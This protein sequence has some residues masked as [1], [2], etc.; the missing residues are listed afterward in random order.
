[1][2]TE[3]ADSWFPGLLR[4]GQSRTESSGVTA[5]S[6]QSALA[7]GKRSQILSRDGGCRSNPH[8]MHCPGHPTV[9]GQLIPGTG[10]ELV[11]G[12]GV[13]FHLFNS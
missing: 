10:K 12:K 5:D 11:R 2:E 13:T 4:A 1:M 6:L 3:G 8:H 9:D 7:Q